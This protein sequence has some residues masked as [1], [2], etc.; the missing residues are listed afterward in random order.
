MLVKPFED[1]YDG[2]T[3]G[4][5]LESS[6]LLL[7]HD[8][9]VDGFSSAISSKQLGLMTP[10]NSS[11]WADVVDLK[12]DVQFT[13]EESGHRKLSC[14]LLLIVG[15]PRLEDEVHPAYTLRYS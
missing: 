8:A 12:K 13:S 10:C 2:G 9:L 5:E 15:L 6:W 11:A 4:S 7:H 14:N 1:G 3:K